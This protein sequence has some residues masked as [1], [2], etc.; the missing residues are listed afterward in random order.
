M[1]EHNISFVPQNAL[2]TACGACSA[3]CGKKAVS[4][5]EN[6]A[7]YLS[8]RVDAQECVNC[9]LCRTVCPSVPE[10]QTI[11]N[12]SATLRGSCLE[13]FIGY[14]TDKMLRREGQ[15]GG[16]V[17]A[18]L[19]YLLESGRI[20]G[21]ITNRFDPERRASVA[22]YATDRQA[23]LESVGSYYVQSPV[24]QTVEQIPKGDKS[25]A[26]VLGCQAEALRMMERQGIPVPDYLIGLVC[27]GT[28]SRQM[29]SDMIAST[30]CPLDEQ[31]QRFRFRY[32]HPAYGGW[33][34]NALLVTDKHR[35]RIDKSV[36]FALKPLYESYRC[37]LCYE[38]INTQADL[39]CGDPWGIPGDYFS[40]ETVVTARTEKGLALLKDAQA[41]GYLTLTP[42]DTELFIR[43]QAI[44]T[45]IRTNVSAGYV[46]SQ[47]HQWAYPYTVTN[48]AAQSFS[49]VSAKEKKGYERRL[50]YTRARCLAHDE[51]EL[52]TLESA[53]RAELEQQAHR[54]AQ[55]ARIKKPFHAVRFV[56][57]KLRRK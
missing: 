6:A 15:S 42:L 8:A 57:R 4:I 16:V 41:A 1:M 10:N 24:V 39:V 38:Q 5:E 30:D 28:Y 12:V 54:N 27:E 13:S 55:K 14:A 44:D 36:R 31:P 21:A 9:G 2:C 23:L 20:N 18:L 25:A 48:E 19:L 29:I 53:Y 32:S 40:G 51:M 35:Y 7:G 52:H 46:C 22:Q 45:Q 50:L 17:T 34:G 37:L 56:I 47:K 33:P 3:V 26:V 43:G 11:S 49:A